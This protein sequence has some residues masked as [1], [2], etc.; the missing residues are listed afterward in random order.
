MWKHTASLGLKTCP[1]EL[2]YSRSNRTPSE[3]SVLEFSGAKM[4]DCL[5]VILPVPLLTNCIILGKFFNLSV[6][7]YLI[8]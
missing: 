8:C 1:V 5:S 2:M 3:N 7:T 6:F 4:L